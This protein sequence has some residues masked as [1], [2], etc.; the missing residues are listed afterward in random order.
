MVFIKIQLSLISFLGIAIVEVLN[1]YTGLRGVD[2]G[3]LSTRR[4][5]VWLWN[6]RVCAVILCHNA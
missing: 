3:R 1:K 5:W 2:D 6:A 4:V